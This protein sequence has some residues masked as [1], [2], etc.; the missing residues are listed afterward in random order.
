MGDGCYNTLIGTK[1]NELFQIWSL[2]PW[3][4]FTAVLL[5]LYMQ[6]RIEAL[7][8]ELANANLL[9]GEAKKGAVPLT[10]EDVEALAP[11]AAAAS[12][13][14][15]SGMSLSQIYNEYV[16]VSNQLEEA[17]AEN[18]QLKDSLESIFNELEA[19]VGKISYGAV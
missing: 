17:S 2:I 3:F 4:L 19:K 7:D 13:M 15:R 6:A 11:S 14:L 10:D 16:K 5:R 8:A 18:T 1:E 9:L 12:K